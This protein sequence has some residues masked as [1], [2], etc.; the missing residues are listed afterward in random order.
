MAPGKVTQELTADYDP[1]AI[2]RARTTQYEKQRRQELL[3]TTTSEA[4]VKHLTR[5]MDPA[6]RKAALDAFRKRMAKAQEKPTTITE[7][8]LVKQVASNGRETYALK[9]ETFD[10]KPKITKFDPH[11]LGISPDE[12]KPRKTFRANGNSYFPQAAEVG[13]FQPHINTGYK[14]RDYRSEVMAA[15]FSNQ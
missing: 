14:V 11:R 5:D 13:D 10:F 4:V 8:V 3:Q 9:P 7:N 2:L 1:E 6:E 12:K 15:L